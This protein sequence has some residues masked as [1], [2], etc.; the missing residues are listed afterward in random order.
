MNPI[1][2]IIIMLPSVIAVCFLAGKTISDWE[3]EQ[4][5]KRKR[6]RPGDQ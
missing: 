1:W 2:T 6:N 4:D 5:Y 3:A